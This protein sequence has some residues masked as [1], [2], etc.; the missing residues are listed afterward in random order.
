MNRIRSLDVFRGLTIFLMII[1]NSPGFTTAYA[2]LMHAKGEG[3]TL[4][5]L[6]F[7]YFLIIMGASS[8]Q[9][10][11]SYRV[12]LLRTLGIFALGLVLNILPNHWDW[13]TWRFLGVLQRIAICY[14]ISACVQRYLQLSEQILLLCGLLVSYAIIVGICGADAL[15]QIDEMVFSSAHLYALHFEPE[16]L[17]STIPAVATTLFGHVLGYIFQQKISR[18][19]KVSQIIFLGFLF[20]SVG[21][22]WHYFWPFNKNIW[23]SSYA[24]WTAGLAYLTWVFCEVWSHRLRL[25]FEILGQYSLSVY[26][27]HIM[28]L[29]LQMLIKVDVNGQST[30][31]KTFLTQIFFGGLSYHNASLAYAV[32]YALFWMGGIYM[33]Q[34]LVKKDGRYGFAG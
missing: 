24:V 29:K 32:S 27:L 16:G 13:H 6:V 21:W 2:I 30:D 3:C 17:L 14:F 4:A 33:L 25:Y 22:I 19:D 11:T 20:C 1:V 18:T 5:D 10:R 23:S 7:P 9:K 8:V 28:G 34:F 12:I 15:A 31:L 26:F